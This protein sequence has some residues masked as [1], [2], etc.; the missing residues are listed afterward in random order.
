MYYGGYRCRN[1]ISVS[2][3]FFYFYLRI[4]S[5]VCLMRKTSEF[6]DTLSVALI[7]HHA[8][9]MEHPV[10]NEVSTQSKLFN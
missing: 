1:I 4:S 5:N 3:I 9:I 8:A 2:I 6:S 10:R 7:W